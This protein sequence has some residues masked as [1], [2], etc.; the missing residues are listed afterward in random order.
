[1]CSGGS[2][3]GGPAAVKAAAAAAAAAVNKAVVP[4]WSKGAAPEIKWRFRRRSRRRSGGQKGG[5]SGGSG[6]SGGGPVAAV[7][8]DHKT[9]ILFLFNLMGIVKA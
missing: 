7:N 9:L 3:S 6:G 8:K 2:G 5:G 1:M 4:V